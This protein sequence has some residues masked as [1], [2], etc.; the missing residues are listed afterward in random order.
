[1]SRPKQPLMSV[2]MEGYET[3]CSVYILSEQDLFTEI[4]IGATELSAT[5]AAIRN[6]EKI[7]KRLK[8]NK[9]KL[10]RAK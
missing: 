5:N 7:L 8:A 1:M 3:S 2:L 4:G 10:E 6:T 9:A